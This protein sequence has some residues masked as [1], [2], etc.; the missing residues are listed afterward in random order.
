MSLLDVSIVVG[1][2]GGGAPRVLAEVKDARAE[3]HR[4]R[5]RIDRT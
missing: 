5:R 1:R 4:G 2:R 3:R